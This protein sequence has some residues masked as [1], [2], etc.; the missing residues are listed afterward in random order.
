MEAAP[1]PTFEMPEPNFLL[2]FLV[3]AS[4]SRKAGTIMDLSVGK[5]RRWSTSM[6]LTGSGRGG[7]VA[8][9]PLHENRVQPTLEFETDGSQRA[10]PA[11]AEY[12]V[13]PDRGNIRAVPNDGNDLLKI[14]GRTLGKKGAHQASTQALSRT[15]GT[16]VD[17]IFNRVPV[18]R[19]RPIR[20][21]IGVADDSAVA[22]G[23]KV[24]KPFVEEVAASPDHFGVAWW[25]DLKGAGRVQDVMTINLGHGSHV[26]FFAGTNARARRAENKALIGV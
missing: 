21:N 4:V 11:K 17:R 7:A 25:F 22:L 13:K 10:N 9:F 12:F 16:N 6:S 20:S 8:E 1:T 15:I 5:A 18:G 23:D 24:R 2:E 19:P 26:A 14:S 3:I